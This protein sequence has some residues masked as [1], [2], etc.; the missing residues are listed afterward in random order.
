MAKGIYFGVEAVAR[1]VRKLYFGVDGVARKVRKTYIGIDGIARLIYI[2][3]MSKTNSA[4]ALTDSTYSVGA[5]SNKGYA[6]FAGGAGA[7]TSVNAYNNLLTKVIPAAL[8]IGRYAIS[9]TTVGDYAIFGGGYDGN[10][11][12][13]HVEA[14]SSSLIKVIPTGLRATTYSHANSVARTTSYAIFTGG[15]SSYS[16]YATAYSDTLIRVATVHDGTGNTNAAGASVNGYAIIGGGYYGNSSQAGVAAYNDS[17]V[18]V[19]AIALSTARHNLR[20]ASIGNS[21][22]LFAGGNGPVSNGTGPVATVDVYDVNLTR[23]TLAPLNRPKMYFTGASLSDY[24]LFAGG[25][26]MY[27]AGPIADVEYYDT[28]LVKTMA[29]SLN[30]AKAYLASAVINDKILI[31]GGNPGSATNEVEVYEA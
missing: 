30:S 6:I 7:V 4:P 23:S 24:A 10:V 9:G 12:Y 1:K 15:A 21:Y 29:P 18:R 8:I 26:G 31:A 2:A 17:L 16:Q 14:Y 3:G 19:T 22:A 11:L 25:T 20:A 27:P 13:A 5:A 28:N